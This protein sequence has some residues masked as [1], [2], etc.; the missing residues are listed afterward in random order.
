MRW[1]VFLMAEADL[2]RISNFAWVSK[3]SQIQMVVTLVHVFFDD[4]VVVVAVRLVVSSSEIHVF[5]NY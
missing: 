1:E 2:L 4:G 5:N 3:Q